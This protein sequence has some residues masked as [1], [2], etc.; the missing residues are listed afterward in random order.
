MTRVTCAAT[1]PTFVINDLYGPLQYN[2]LPALFN[3]EAKIAQDRSNI[4]LCINGTRQSNNMTIECKNVI[5][6]VRGLAETLFHITLES[7]CKFALM[8]Y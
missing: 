8:T 2:Q 6:T 4:T 5:D 7:N 3:I 1:A